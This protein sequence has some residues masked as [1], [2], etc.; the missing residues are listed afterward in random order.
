M[1][2][3]NSV[4]TTADQV[5]ILSIGH[6]NLAADDLVA[7]LKAHQIEIVIDVRS[8]PYSQ[9]APQFNRL[10]LAQTL[11]KA[12]IDYEF[13]GEA[14][15]GRPTDPTCYR[16]GE[17]PP[18]KANYLKEVDYQT[19]ATKSWYL[20]GLDRLIEIATEK[21]TAIMCSE[22]D[23]SRCHR[24]HLIAHTLLDRDIPV[25]HIRKSGERERAARSNSEPT[26]EQAA[27]L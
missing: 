25:W 4:T 3:N 21:P 6:S 1:A 10:D 13:A 23:P 26:L 2:G 24:H 18:P 7:A 19:V 12:S 8:S 14:L 15:G 16:N 22:E 20:E 17:I 9:F 11:S 27:L 5:E